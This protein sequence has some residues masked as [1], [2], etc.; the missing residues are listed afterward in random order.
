MSMTPE[1]ASS[2]N[3]VNSVAEYLAGKFLAKGYLVY[4]Q[5]LDAVQTADGWYYEYSVNS[6]TYLAD[7]TFG[8]AATAA[9]GM[10]AIVPAIPA[11]PRF[12]SRPTLDGTVL[13]ES[14]VGIP[15]IAIEV[16]AP[17]PQFR[18]QLGSTMHWRRRMLTLDCYTRTQAE[19]AEWQD[20]LALWFD[21][22]VLIPLRDHENTG[23]SLED[24]WSTMTRIDSN[25]VLNRAEAEAFQ[26]VLTTFLEYIA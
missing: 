9:K 11:E 20:W 22:D 16:G 10:V 14:H 2:A 26:V 25:T 5:V 6:A 1:Q 17:D 3:I 15:A 24:G 12:V 4:W 8:A 7:A 18:Y 23:L 13:P 21:P 19:Q